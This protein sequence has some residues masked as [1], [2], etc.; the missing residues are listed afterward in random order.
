[1]TVELITSD[2]HALC[3]DS[4][5]ALSDEWLETDAGLIEQHLDGGQRLVIQEDEAIRGVRLRVVAWLVW[6]EL[7][8][9]P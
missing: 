5:L 9:T 6:R 8:R 7:L 4:P 1:M 3:Y 2:V